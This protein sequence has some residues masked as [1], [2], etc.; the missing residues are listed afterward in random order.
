MAFRLG[1]NVQLKYGGPRMRVEKTTTS[2]GNEWV[3]CVW[4]VNNECHNYFAAEM[5]QSVGGRSTPAASNRPETSLW[6]RLTS[7]L[8]S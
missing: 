1:D 8:R 7:W 3:T 4:G 2:S 6:S 5:L